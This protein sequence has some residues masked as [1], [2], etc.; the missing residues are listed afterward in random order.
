MG[1]AKITE[2]GEKY[3]VE[4]AD[5]DIHTGLTLDEAAELLD[6]DTMEVKQA[7]VDGQG[8]IG[9]IEIDEEEEEDNDAEEE[10][11]L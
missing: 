9:Y 11:E 2:H 7:I 4:D 3:D 8:G 1:T 5:G 6:V 10:D